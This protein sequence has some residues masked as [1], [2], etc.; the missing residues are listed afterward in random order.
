R[1]GRPRP[2]ALEVPMDVLAGVTDAV[3]RERVAPDPLRPAP[4]AIEKAA[5]VLRKAER[6]LLYVGGGINASDGHD[7]LRDLAERR[8]A[9]GVVSD[10]GCGAIDSRD[11]HAFDALAIRRFRE[12]A[13]VVLAVGTRLATAKGTLVDV[14]KAERILL[15]AEETDLYGPREAS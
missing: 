13:D 1:S 3:A 10:S 14:G 15:N 5:A 6:P 8:E 9:P 4:G 2:V 11:R 7:A 12:D